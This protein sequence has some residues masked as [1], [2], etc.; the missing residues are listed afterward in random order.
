MKNLFLFILAVSA[1]FSCKDSPEQIP[2]YLKIE[3]FSVSEKG[4][5][6]WQKL[7][8][9]MVYVNGEYLGAYSFNKEFPVL[10][11]G[12]ADVVVFPGIYANG[13]LSSPAIYSPL[14][15]F[16][17][18]INL[19]PGETAVAKPTTKYEPTV[20]QPWGEEGE[21][22]N[23]TLFFFDLDSDSTTFVRFDADNAFEGRSAKLQADTGHLLNVV[24]TDWVKKLPFAGAQEIWL[25]M[26][27]RCDAPFE[28]YLEGKS[29]SHAPTS[30]LLFIFNE[31]PTWN[32]IYLSLREAVIQSRQEEYRLVF[33]VS[34]P[35][36]E[37]GKYPQ[38]KVS[39][40]FDN[41][42]IAHF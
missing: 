42:K 28:L 25:E 17:A 21:F 6:A 24:A 41:L 2:A 20:I 40:Q 5:A 22:D 29:S 39:V 34:V 33:K 12:E 37:N 26:H 36:D 7:A 23:S 32:K 15:R 3:P 30:Q 38:T 18:K 1:F 35:R 9:A 13:S 8:L 27:Y 16:D 10:A 14:A 4:G 19:K 11:E 31:K